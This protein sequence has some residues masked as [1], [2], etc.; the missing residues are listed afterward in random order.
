MQPKLEETTLQNVPFSFPL[1]SSLKKKMQSIG[2]MLNKVL[3]HVCTT[4]SGPQSS[5]EN[6]SCV[7]FTGTTEIAKLYV[8]I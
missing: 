4:F 1:S 5:L 3:F 2:Q 6:P 8:T 7:V